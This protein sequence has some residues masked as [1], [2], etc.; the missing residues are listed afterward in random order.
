MD[1]SIDRTVNHSSLKA[2]VGAA[3]RYR[4]CHRSRVGLRRSEVLIA[5]ERVD[6]FLVVRQPSAA[7]A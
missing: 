5:A 7:A 3:E 1:L 6:V 4:G 2:R